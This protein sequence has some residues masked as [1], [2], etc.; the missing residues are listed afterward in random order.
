MIDIRASYPGGPQIKYDI[1]T[2]PDGSRSIKFDKKAI[3]DLIEYSAAEDN[4]F[5]VY[6]TWKGYKSDDELTTLLYLTKHFQD[7]FK[8]NPILDM[9]Y[10]VNARMDRT[11]DNSEV[12][13][14]KYFCEF[15]NSLN[16]KSVRVFDPHSS[17][18]QGL[19][20]RVTIDNPRTYVIQT[21][22]EITNYGQRPI[23]L[24]FPDEGAVKRYRDLLD[25]EPGSKYEYI[26]TMPYIV[27]KKHREWKNGEI[28][29][30]TVEVQRHLNIDNTDDFENTPVLM[31]DDIIS[32]GGTLAYSADELAKLGFKEVY[33]YASHTENS[34][35]D[36][37][38][39][40]LWKRVESGL[41]KK[42]YTTDS[43]LTEQ[44]Y[45]IKTYKLN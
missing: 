33:A 24:Y 14:L 26:S 35:L 6:F 32:Y 2:Y 27:G 4:N 19:I 22:N 37:E 25:F 23:Y 11:K 17:L 3:A 15:I 5:D 18:V 42:I 16:F 1:I 43:L 20:Q 36:K 28:T 12:F 13:T 31:I 40:K 44:N 39:G 38:K 41:V 10:V 30:L 21:I 34:L 7:V 8:L 29:S 45:L 9:F